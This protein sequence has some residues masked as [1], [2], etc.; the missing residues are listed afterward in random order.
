MTPEERKEKIKRDGGLIDAALKDVFG[1]GEDFKRSAHVIV[2]GKRLSVSY[3]PDPGRV[4]LAFTFSGDGPQDTSD[5]EGETSLD[6]VGKNLQAGTKD[7]FDGLRVF[8]HRLSRDGI[9]VEY[10]AE[11]R[12]ARLYS[13]ILES[14]GF[15]PLPGN[16]MDPGLKSWGPVVGDL[17]AGSP[18]LTRLAAMEKRINGL[19][20]LPEPRTAAIPG[21][22]QRAS[23]PTQLPDQKT[24]PRLPQGNSERLEPARDLPAVPTPSAP[25][26]TSSTPP[27]DDSPTARAM[28]GLPALFRPRREPDPGTVS[29]SQSAPDSPSVPVTSVPALPAAPAASWG[30]RPIRDLPGAVSTPVSAPAAVS[31]YQAPTTVTA[32]TAAL[33]TVRAAQA[34]RT[35]PAAPGRRGEA[36]RAGGAGLP[37][38]TGIPGVSGAVGASSLG[39]GSVGESGAAGLPGLPGSPG[40]TALS[41]AFSWQVTSEQREGSEQLIAAIKELTQAL[42]EGKK[43]DKP[44]I[45][46]DGSFVPGG[47]APLPKEGRGGA[48][49][50]EGAIEG[51]WTRGFLRAIGRR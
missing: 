25:S 11:D 19:R 26:Q 13:K 12:R 21:S 8:T 39:V 7:F 10:H 23:P 18:M 45:Q 37:G 47:A 51:P 27:Q 34:I 5:K 16:P 14:T 36:G 48:A 40:A 50:P 31:P 29:S 3:K 43:D 32:P 44:G 38:A 42:R 4:Y 20:G 49:V 41:K 17:S 30:T 35:L 33:E 15:K 28:R 1:H 46:E 6:V 24:T 9:G 22:N 2:G